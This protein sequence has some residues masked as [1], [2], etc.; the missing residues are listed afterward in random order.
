VSA[1]GHK[2]IVWSVFDEMKWNTTTMMMQ[3]LFSVVRVITS[4]PTQQGTLGAFATNH[5]SVKGIPHV[6]ASS[7]SRGRILQLL[8]IP[9]LAALIG[10]Y[11]QVYSTIT[12]KKKAQTS[13]SA[14]TRDTAIWHVNILQTYARFLEQLF[15]ILY[16]IL[17][18]HIQSS[19]SA[20]TSP[21][22]L[23]G[24]LSL[25]FGNKTTLSSGMIPIGKGLVM[26]EVDY[27]AY[28]EAIQSA[29]SLLPTQSF[30][31]MIA[32]WIRELFESANNKTNV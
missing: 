3:Q 23:G 26:K 8:S 30:T 13:T 18:L 27:T 4:V 2:V 5:P 15:M 32:R 14:I 7:T 12:N 22:L 29:E 19:T 25:G 21:F 17:V 6:L 31:R 9:Q 10:E 16:Q 28:Q 11:L 24:T 20:S 1:H